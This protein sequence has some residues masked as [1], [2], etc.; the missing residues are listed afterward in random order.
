MSVIFLP[1]KKKDLRLFSRF[2]CSAERPRSRVELLQTHQ[3]SVQ[4]CHCVEESC[5]HNSLA[6]APH[7]LTQLTAA[8]FKQERKAAQSTLVT[9]TTRH[10]YLKLIIKKKKNRSNKI[11]NIKET[12]HNLPTT[13]HSMTE[14]CTSKRLHQC[15]LTPRPR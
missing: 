4:W 13:S 5:T 1:L 10:A 2:W 11:S 3:P 15:Q 7:N 9:Q 8:A 12:C 6:A 14:N